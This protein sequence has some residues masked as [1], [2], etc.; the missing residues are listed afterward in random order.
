MFGIGTTELFVIVLVGILVLGPEHLPRIIRTVTK[1]MSDVRR[2]STDFQRTVNL[3]INKE[4]W[5][6][7]QA[8]EEQKK[9][10]KKKAPAEPEQ[11]PAGEEQTPPTV[12]LAEQEQTPAAAAM[13]ETQGS[14]QGEK[15]GPAQGIPRDLP[16]SAPEGAD[17]KGGAVLSSPETKAQEAP[18]R[19]QE[20]R[21]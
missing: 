10:K 14:V 15:Q 7:K 17:G 13:A 19:S 18:I 1:V 16:L 21:A 20:G 9:K 11:T 8:E 2:V 12:L 6:K 4:E 5:E 3:E